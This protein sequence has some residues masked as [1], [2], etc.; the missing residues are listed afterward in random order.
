MFFDVQSL[1]NF[2]IESTLKSDLRIYLNTSKKT[3]R[4]SQLTVSIHQIIVPRK[5]YRLITRRII[6]ASESQWHDFDILEASL[7]WKE[8]PEQ[9]KGVVVDCRS[10][11]KKRR[12]MKECGLVD[13]KG[14]SENIPFLVSF[15]QSGDE[16][17]LLAEQLPQGDQG[18]KFKFQEKGNVARS[19][20]SLLTLFPH[21]QDS[22]QRYQ[23]RSEHPENTTCIRHA[24][25][26]RFKDLGWSEYIIAPEGYEA[27]YCRGACPFPLHD[28]M[29]AS[30]H[31]IIQTLVHLISSDIPQ[32]CCSPLRLAPLKVL[33]YNENT[34]I[35]MKRY[36]NMVVHDCGCQ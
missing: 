9:N 21:A 12:T 6:N 8:Y 5:E 32:P 26:I 31:A 19:K 27:A 10:S 36:T 3:L 28:N 30:N 2:V 34:S 25:Y 24:L 15:Y 13:F 14:E 20:R 7:L 16:D 17:E 23:T 29:N 35:V 18:D 4:D 1:L 11:D 33:F 22:F